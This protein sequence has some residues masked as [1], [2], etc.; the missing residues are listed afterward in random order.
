M[1]LPH[2]N[3]G[4]IV[5]VRPLGDALPNSRTTTLV[6][7]DGLEI[8]RL[9][10]PTGK[11]IPVHRA[12]DRL[13]V[14][15][16]EGKIAFTAFGKTHELQQGQL[17]HLPPKEPHSVRGIE[18]GSLLLILLQPVKESGTAINEVEEASEESFPASDA[19][20]WTGGARP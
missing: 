8:I 14:Q 17:L 1:A 18:D 11:E 13:I 19:P 2:A 7:T 9:V 10:V 3:A 5:D 12:P 15:C 4:E 20:A 6:K 16:L